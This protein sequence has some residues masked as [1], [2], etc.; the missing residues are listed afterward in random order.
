MALRPLLDADVI[1]QQ[2]HVVG[3]DTFELFETIEDSFGVELG[4]YRALCGLTITELGCEVSKRANY[5]DREKCLSAAS[6]YRLR[7]ALQK[8]S[9]A[10]RAA[11]RP[12][13]PS[14]EL[15]PWKSRRAQWQALEQRIGL[16]LPGLMFPAWLLCLCLVT[17]AAFLVYSK[18]FW[19]LPLGWF[20]LF[21]WWIWLVAGTLWAMSPFARS[22]PVD[23]ETIGGLTKVVLA[24]NYAAFAKQN[25]GSSEDD[26][27]SALQQLVA[28]QT[29]R[30]VDEI[31]PYT[32]IP[33]G[34]NIY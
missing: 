32:V 11:I 10:P 7:Q 18:L 19:G 5:P 25:C 33:Q 12:A 21:F 15:L 9:N 30:S 24:R 13:T 29:C 27:L 6:F 2:D 26:L 22:L 28:T 34:L 8:L 4:D 3:E 31:P 23:C 20:G 14:A 16:T 1:Y 17:S